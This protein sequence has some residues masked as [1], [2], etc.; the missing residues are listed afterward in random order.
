MRPPARNHGLLRDRVLRG[1]S[2]STRWSPVVAVYYVQ[3]PSALNPLE[4]V[5]PGDGLWRRRSSSSR[6]RPAWIADTYSRRALAWSSPSARRD[7]PGSLIGLVPPP[8]PVIVAAL[9]L[10]GSVTPSSA[11]RIR[12]GSPTRSAPISVARVFLRNARVRLRRSA[13]RGAPRAWPRS[14]TVDLG[15]AVAARGRPLRLALTALARVFVMPETGFTRKPAAERLGALRDVKLAHGRR[16][17]AGSS[18]AERAPCSPDRP[19]S[20]SSSEWR[21]RRRSTNR[22]WEA[23]LDPRSRAAEPSAGWIRS[24]GSA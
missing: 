7:W 24:S 21:P 1:T 18:R 12:P 5:L 9:R 10:W 3:P 2:A 20:P 16:R 15:A 13:C 23:H 22:L 14:R 17:D 6:S 11:V 8:F 4:L 19:R